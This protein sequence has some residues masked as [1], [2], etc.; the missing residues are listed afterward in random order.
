MSSLL[1]DSHKICCACRGFDC[2]MD[3]KCS[4]CE[5]W[6]EEVMIKYVKYRK[7]LDSKSNVRKEKKTLRLYRSTWGPCQTQTDPSVRSP[8]IDY[9]SGGEAQEPVQVGLA[10]SSFIASLLVLSFRRA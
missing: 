4:E 7:S 10:S 6:S 3:K 9:G 8:C 2:S 5:A 1:H